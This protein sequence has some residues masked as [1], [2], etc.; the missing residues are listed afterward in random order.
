MN[1]FI[2][3]FQA[4]VVF[5]LSCFDRVIFK[6]YLPFGN[7]AH[8]NTFVDFGLKIL[9]KDFIPL[10][11][12]MSQQL[13]EH[14]QKLAEEAGAP[15]YY[16]QGK[17]KKEAFIDKIAA[18]RKHPDGLIA[19]LCVQETCR[20]VKLRWGEGKPRLYFDR[21]PQRVLYFYY[22][23]PEFGRM[24]VRLQTWFPFTIQ[25]YVNGHEW[26]ARQMMAHG[27][28]FVQQ[29]NCFTELDDP[30]RAQELAD[31]FV[32][33]RWR[34]RLNRWA[35]QVNCLLGEGFLRD[36]EYRWILEQVEYSTDLVFRDRKSLA[37]LYPR[38]LDH[39]VVNFT[40][41][42]ILSFLGRRLDRRFDGEVV[43]ECKKDREPGARI[44]H[45][46]K[47]N[48]L[49]MYDKAAKVLRTETV[50]NQPREFKVRR[51]RT[52]H[53]KRQLVWCP[54]NKGIA[55]FYQYA[56]VARAA[57]QRYLDA[58]S[59]VHDPGKS[60]QHVQT[61]V[62]PKVVGKRTY[63]GFNPAN[64]TDIRLFQAVL[65]G[66][67]IVRGF[68]N[69]D[70]RRYLYGEAKSRAQRRRQSARVGR[71]LKRLHVR[72]WIKKVPRTRLW[73]VTEQGEALLGAV[74]RLYYHGL[75]RV[76]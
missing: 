42:D 59:V 57:N 6:G 24:Y 39:A 60:Y 50:I 64:K 25:I 44:K 8:L 73:R 33:L 26:L 68:R 10:V 66:D 15:Y 58:L 34:T 52:R 21:R 48:W 74:V 23:D 35:R 76:A 3:K 53:G 41:E 4:S 56:A 43:T 28:G 1:K 71:L 19:V 54:M 69:S 36:A 49:K 17:L 30:K 32:R 31:R 37:P 70:I 22:Q 12:K 29:D 14:A 9:R 46:M 20:T 62:R 7:D 16:R 5:C 61:L 38:L 45:R 72:G 55:N 75:A 13:V 63:A 51:W 47:G 40:A 18:E 65:H 27:V 11:Q 2:E 67:H